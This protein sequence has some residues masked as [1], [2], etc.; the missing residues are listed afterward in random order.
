MHVLRPD[1]ELHENL[2]SQT[3]Q[4]FVN[5]SIW[6]RSPMSNTFYDKF[7]TTLYHIKYSSLKTLQEGNKA[8]QSN[9]ANVLV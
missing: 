2:F 3:F 1:N 8:C 7:A 5:I 4:M 6:E 9:V